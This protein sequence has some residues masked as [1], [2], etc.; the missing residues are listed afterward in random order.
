MPVLGFVRSSLSGGL[1]YGTAQDSCK[2]YGRI[3]SGV[4]FENQYSDEMPFALMLC[5][6]ILD[7]EG[8]GEEENLVQADSAGEDR[9]A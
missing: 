7:E 6:E 1:K 9:D 4:S 2:S 5:L 8:E 3:P